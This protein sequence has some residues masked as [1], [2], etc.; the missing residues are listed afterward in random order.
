MTGT[1]AGF[2]IL[3]GG[4]YV[5]LSTQF[6]VWHTDVWG[7]LAY[8]R[9]IW[10][11][12]GLPTT[13]PLMP[14]SRGA[15]FVDTAWLAQLVGYVLYSRLG[16]AGLKVAYAVPLTV[17]LAVL[18]AMVYRR[19]RSIVW[20]LVALVAFAWI[21]YE[22]LLIVRPQL[23]G[24]VCFAVLYG[25]FG[26]GDWRRSHWW[27]VPLLFAAW[28]NLHGSYPV[29]L[30]LIAVAALGR[31]IDV[32]G[33][34]RRLARVM[35]DGRARRLLAVLV[36]AAIAT[37]LNP[38]GLRVYEEVLSVARNPN[39]RDLVEWRPL[40]VQ[41]PHGL[42]AAVVAIVLF[43]AYRLSRRR[44]RA[45]EV[46]LL[47][48]LG[49]SAL[50]HSRMLV[51][52]GVVAADC[53]AVH[54]AGA[55]GQGRPV[56]SRPGARAPAWSVVSLAAAT[57][58]FLVSPPGSVLLRGRAT[59]AAQLAEELRGNVSGLT[60]IGA[61]EFL[62]EHPPPGLLFNTYEWGDYLLWA[63]PPGVEVF[64]ASHAHL[65]PRDVWLDY[66]QV[67][68]ASARWR[69]ILDRYGVSTVMVDRAGR[70]ALI[71]LLREDSAWRIVYEDHMAVVFAREPAA[72]TV[73]TPPHGPGPSS[74]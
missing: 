68:R 73:P 60:P 1:A 50:V 54:L 20:T 28:A 69:E 30:V 7:H 24:L 62:N 35:A 48:I 33:R 49:L 42:A 34:T 63:G 61:V 57:G 10:R 45:A 15:S 14:L 32:G 64:V 65:V 26:C 56:V 27:A 59:D 44:M 6:P 52:W 2:T 9:E 41:M 5:V 40:S 17:V 58:C 37:C 36:L 31:A 38:Y 66:L 23:A 12:G 22:P 71:R 18:S 39:L 3:L 74:S 46:L 53:V 21:N 51:W 4:L 25:W 11:Q 13:E 70:G 29:G 55:W 19:T 43:V 16:V 67:S 72:V 8:G 47:S